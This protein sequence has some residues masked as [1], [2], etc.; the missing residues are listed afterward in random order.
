MYDTL[1]ACMLVLFPFYNLRRSSLT[2][3]CDLTEFAILSTSHKFE[4]S[5]MGLIKTTND[6]PEAW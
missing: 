4:N 5:S 6:M 2:R 1:D 3:M